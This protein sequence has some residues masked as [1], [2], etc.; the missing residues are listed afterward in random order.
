[1]KAVNVFNFTCVYIL[2]NLTP[3]TQY[4]I[5]VRAVKLIG[6][7]I[8][9]GNNSITVGAKTLFTR[10]AQG[11]YISTH[12]HIRCYTYSIIC[13]YTS[14]YLVACLPPNFCYHNNN[15]MG[16]FIQ[17]NGPCYNVPLYSL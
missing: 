9:E 15:S 16:H 8:L 14:M 4:S 6:D 1:M 17:F 13:T 12:N 3:S 5:H 2:K 11:S 10:T 7:I